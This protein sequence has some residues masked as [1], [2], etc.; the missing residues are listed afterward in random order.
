M[1]KTLTHNIKE[2]I[3][4]KR[5]DDIN[6]FIVKNKVFATQTNTLKIGMEEHLITTIFYEIQK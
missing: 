5:D 3:S 6:I 4:G 1:I 2:V